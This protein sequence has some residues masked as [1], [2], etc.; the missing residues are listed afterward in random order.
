MGFATPLSF[1]LGRPSKAH[2]P[3]VPWSTRKLT[4]GIWAVRTTSSKLFKPTSKAKSWQIKCACICV[5]WAENETLYVITACLLMCWHRSLLSI[6]LPIGLTALSLTEWLCPW[7]LLC[8][9]SLL[10]SISKS[11]KVQLRSPHRLLVSRLSI[12]E[13]GIKLVTELR[14]EGAA[15][16]DEGAYTSHITNEPCHKRSLVHV[17][18]RWSCDGIFIYAKMEL[19]IHVITS[20]KIISQ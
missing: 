20:A 9:R 2:S 3:M 18:F 5:M 14:V 17:A 6:R 7:G 4:T 15:V 19:Y 16:D 11:Q 12:L 13:A 1:A 8:L 10:L